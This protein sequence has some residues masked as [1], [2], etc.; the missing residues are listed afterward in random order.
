MSDW[1]GL[2][3]HWLDVEL[4]MRIQTLVR[5]L[6]GLVNTNIGWLSSWVGEYKQGLDVWLDWRIQT[7]VKYLAGQVN[8][9][10][11]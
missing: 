4:N 7:L 10:N 11:G 9:N 6:A 1:A 8:T 2:Y 3:K 5:C